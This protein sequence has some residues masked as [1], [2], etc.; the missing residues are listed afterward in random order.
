ME[1]CNIH[2]VSRYDTVLVSLYLLL[3]DGIMFHHLL[4]RSY[5]GVSD[6]HSDLGTEC[7][8]EERSAFSCN[9]DRTGNR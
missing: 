7:V 5:N 2:T 1:G 9:K 8:V 3:C 6:R 4:N